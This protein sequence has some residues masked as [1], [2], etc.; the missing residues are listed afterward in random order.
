V[1]GIRPADGRA[2]G[3]A[4]MQGKGASPCR[5]WCRGEGFSRYSFPS[6]AARQAS[7]GRS[8]RRAWPRSPGGS[9]MRGCCPTCARRE[10]AVNS[11]GVKRLCLG[12]EAHPG[13]PRR[14][15]PLPREA[16]S[17]RLS[18][19]FQC[20][21]LRPAYR[22]GMP[23]SHGATRY[24]DY[25]C[26]CDVCRAAHAERHR[27]LRAQR[28]AGRPD[29]NPAL[30]HGTRSTYVNHGCRCEQCVEAQREGN[31]RRPSPTKPGAVTAEDR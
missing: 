15:H 26:R 31:R 23:P 10:P 6:R 5:V 19:R 3:L 17:L 24:T 12:H 2:Q 25:G 16:G 11:R 20:A 4:P 29:E 27:R 8:T 21:L 13:E 7:R 18:R 9:G 30:E 1:E 14:S 22:D 28:A